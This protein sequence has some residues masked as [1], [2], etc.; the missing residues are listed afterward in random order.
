[1][2]RRNFFKLFGGAIAAAILPLGALALERRDP[3]EGWTTYADV[4]FSG[5]L[6]LSLDD[7]EQC[8]LNPAIQRLA[9]QIDTEMTRYLK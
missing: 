8:I 6:N 5:D 9:E 7:F 1:M 4:H 2:N 3:E